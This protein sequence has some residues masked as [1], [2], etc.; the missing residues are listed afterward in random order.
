M[1]SEQREEAIDDEL[2]SRVDVVAFGCFGCEAIEIAPEFWAL[3]FLGE[4]RDGQAAGHSFRS[5]WSE[6]VDHVMGRGAEAGEAKPEVK[7]VATFGPLV[8]RTYL[9][10]EKLRCRESL[11]VCCS[12]EPARFH[13]ERHAFLWPRRRAFERVDLDLDFHCSVARF[14]WRAESDF[15]VSGDLVVHLHAEPFADSSQGGHEFSDAAVA[16]PNVIEVLA[17]SHGRG[18]PELME[19]CSAPKDE[20]V[21]EVVVVGDLDDEPR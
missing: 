7:E 6:G 11:N 3:E 9:R 17:V 2:S 12:G 10:R 15:R 8:E 21:A 18:D 4:I 14:E 5:V 16:A 1:C 19:A 20:F 13:D